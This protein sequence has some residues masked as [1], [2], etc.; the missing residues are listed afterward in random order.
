MAASQNTGNPDI[1]YNLA[2]AYFAKGCWKEAIDH[3]RQAVAIS[4][5]FAKALNNLAVALKN[6]GDTQTAIRIF[7]NA[8]AL[9]PDNA[10]FHNN[11]GIACQV[12]GLQYEALVHF[13]KAIELHPDF[14]EAI[15]NLGFLL[16]TANQAEAAIPY[17][18]KALELKPDFFSAHNNLAVTLNC[19][20]DFQKARE[21]Y[22]RAVQLQPE[23]HDARWNRSML[24]LLNGE[25]DEGWRE[26]EY[27]LTQ[28][29]W[30]TN[31]PSRH[32]KP[33]WNG[34]AL[35]GKC[36]LIHDEQGYG[37]TL[38][39]IRY[40]PMVEKNSGRI[41]F[42]TRRPLA[43]LLS[44]F[45]NIDE[46]IIR[47]GNQRPH[48]DYD[49]YMP[50]LSLPMIFRTSMHNIPSP[51]GYLQADPAKAGFW[52]KKLK[53]RDMKVGIIWAGNPAHK[54]DRNRSCL[55]GNFE[56]LMDLR[57]VHFYSLQKDAEPLNW[58]ALSCAYAITDCSEDLNDF[59]DT[60]ALIHNLDL[61]ISVDTAV[62][63]LAGAMGKPAWLLLPFVPDWRWMQK[64]AD[65]PWYHSLRLFRQEKNGDWQTV[66]EKVKD[67]LRKAYSERRYDKKKPDFRGYGRS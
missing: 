42:E 55:F 58:K 44:K 49:A 5:A 48:V 46:I 53:T 19:L 26:F 63:H 31:Y 62:V 29:G 35:D 59:T 39:F 8:I 60:A 9:E 7:Q 65:S 2:N 30:A 28:S 66:F 20:G 18:E 4:P 6:T 15:F 24:L 17:Y 47:T 1:H 61:V 43:S 25:F 50:L 45:P 41:V 22:D 36:L 57:G 14:S 56:G 33:R 34:S 32:N 64:R 52:R 51:E 11:L 3:Y 27:R 38:Q 10:E 54:N 12:Q 40:I 67:E 23:N 21:H 37:D 13:E 16:Q